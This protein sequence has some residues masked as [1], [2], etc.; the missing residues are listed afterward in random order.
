MRIHC[1]QYVYP[2][3]C[4]LPRHLIHLLVNL[5]GFLHTS[6][7]PM[8]CEHSRRNRAI[9]QKQNYSKPGLRGLRGPSLLESNK[10]RH[11]LSAISALKDHT[12]YCGSN[13]K[14][15]KNHCHH[16]H[17]QRSSLTKYDSIAIMSKNLSI[18]EFDRH[19]M[20]I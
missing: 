16:H 20:S 17:Y 2:Q 5:N 7:C 13:D 1:A 10:Q 6:D 12:N 15:T 14:Q 11:F 3:T 18:R 9:V 19:I 4:L 8:F